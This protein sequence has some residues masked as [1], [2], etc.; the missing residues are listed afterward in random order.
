MDETNDPMF[1]SNAPTF[2]RAETVDSDIQRQIMAL[3]PDNEAFSLADLQESLPQHDYWRLH[4]ALTDLRKTGQISF[5]HT[6]NR[7]K[8]FVKTSEISL[9]RF[10]DATG[11]GHP[12]SA[13]VIGGPNGFVDN[14]DKHYRTPS[15][16]IISK[17]P[18]AIAKLFRLAN[19]DMSDKARMNEW[20]AIRA[21]LIGIRMQAVKVT[22]VIDGILAHGSMMGDMKRF[23]QVFTESANVPRIDETNDAMTWATNEFE[24]D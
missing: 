17:L 16:K 13:F 3:V 21:D 9:P 23:V 4:R 5:V 20:K 6:K 15:G 1:D 8:F 2:K 19:K 18:I 14:F 11:K 24:E 10:R 22:E 12:I 7:R